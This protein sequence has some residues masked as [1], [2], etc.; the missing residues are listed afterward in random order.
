[1]IEPRDES[2]VRSLLVNHLFKDTIGP[3]WVSKTTDP[4]YDEELI[5]TE[6]STPAEYYLTGYLRPVQ[7]NMQTTPTDPDTAVGGSM[8]D[9]S[10]KVSGDGNFMQPSSMGCT[11]KPQDAAG[12]LEVIASWGIYRKVSKPIG[13]EQTISK[14][15]L[16]I[17]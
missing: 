16:L 5:L 6:S 4:D 7:Q 3:S 2:E 13:R 12:G 17:K 10:G 1:M 11:V 9:N 8:L 14:S 15:F